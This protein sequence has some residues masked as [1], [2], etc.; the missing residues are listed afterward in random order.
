MNDLMDRGEPL[1]LQKHLVLVKRVRQ[2]AIE[3]RQFSLG[4]PV[5]FSSNTEARKY[6]LTITGS[7][8][9]SA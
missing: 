8:G 9:K 7:L 6:D 4:T 2:H 5:F 3:N 1:P